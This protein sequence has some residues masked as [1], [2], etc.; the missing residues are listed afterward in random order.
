VVRYLIDQA[1]VDRQ[2][3]S[4]VGYTDTQ[5]RTSNDSEEGRSSNR[6]I[7]IELDPKDLKEIA[8]HVGT[9]TPPSK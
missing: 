3:L 7:E 2:H 6:Q 8:G 1:S 4:V 9:N 5:P